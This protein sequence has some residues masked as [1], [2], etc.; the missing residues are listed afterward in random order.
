MLAGFPEDGH[1]VLDGDDVEAV[2]RVEL[3]GDGVF[4]IEE[5]AVVLLDGEVESLSI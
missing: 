2:V 1:D 5:H 3:D 4:G